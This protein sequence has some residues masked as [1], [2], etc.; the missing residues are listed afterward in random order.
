MPNFFCNLADPD[1][2]YPYCINFSAAIAFSVLFG[3]STI[4]HFAQAIYFRKRFC[5]VVVMAGLWE[6]TSYIFRALSAYDISPQGFG[7]PSQLLV[8]LAPLWI[9]AFVYM[10]FGRVV[11]Y[12]LPDKRV[13]HLS[14]HVLSVIFV[15]LDVMSFLIQGTGAILAQSGSDAPKLKVTGFH[16][17]QGGVG[18]QQFSIVLF[19]VL[20]IRCQVK[21]KALENEGQRHRETSWRKAL[22]PIYGALL[23]ITIRTIYRLTEFAGGFDSGIS[24]NEPAFYA[25][26][27]T[28]MIICMNIF[29]IWHPGA[30]LVG[31]GSEF[32]KK[33]K[34][35]KSKKSKD[36]E[37][38]ASDEQGIALTEVRPSSQDIDIESSPS[39]SKPE[40]RPSDLDPVIT[41][42]MVD[43]PYQ[44]PPSYT[45]D[46]GSHTSRGA[47]WDKGYYH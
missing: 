34:K 4:L 19:I 1:Y 20:V 45:H 11:Y 36:T 21:L 37:V 12:F 17:Y 5:W 13:G 14:A 39:F 6:T 47:G 41:P 26:E 44:N 35:S 46:H 23:L 3:L 33:D 32:K 8:Q 42:S 2:P 7:I 28:M 27:A 43:T 9:N 38:A 30:V 24:K 31:Q 18:A 40:R 10:V 25:L 29:N 22:F 15:L 16:V